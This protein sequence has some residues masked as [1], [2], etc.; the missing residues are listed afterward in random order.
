MEAIPGG[1]VPIE[2]LRCSKEF[3]GDYDGWETNVI[4]QREL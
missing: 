2:L 1:S 4:S 3:Q